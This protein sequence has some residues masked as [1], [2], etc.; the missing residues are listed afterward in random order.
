MEAVV[1]AMAGAGPKRVEIP[2]VDRE[3]ESMW[4]TIAPRNGEESSALLMHASVV[5]LVAV[6][7]S[8]AEA[9]NAAEVIGRIIGR[10]PCRALVLEAAED[11][12]P[13]GVGAEISVI[14]EQAPYGERQVCCELIR[15]K[16][17]GDSVEALP[18]T[19]ASFYVPD[20]P[21]VVWWPAPPMHREDFIRFAAGSDRVVID[22]AKF[23]RGG[24][25][26][27]QAFVGRSRKA[28]TAIG[29]L[30]WARL[31]PYRQLLA[32]FF[33]APHWREQ[34][35][36][37][38]RVEIEAQDTAGLLVGGWLLSRLNRDR[39]ALTADQITF[40][41]MAAG[42]AVF[43]SIELKCAGGRFSV[44]RTGADTVEAGAA[45]GNES[46]SRVARIGLAPLEHLLGAEIEYLG[47]D[48]A[49]DAAVEA[50]AELIG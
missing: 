33:D 39:Y 20:L 45:V 32:Q 44:V 21:V 43:Y 37:I 34:L 28:R 11:E 19:A 3:L 4:K 31:T 9:D 23:G 47:R 24:L 30:N 5:N 16:A 22:S 17:K 15:L 26:A 38:E 12:S 27:A 36:R 13:S 29:D 10:S 50:A 8:T 18:N 25:R 7:D 35:T 42:Q 2:A 1:T 40:K 14:C 48:R 41:K 49:Y 46:S 6:T